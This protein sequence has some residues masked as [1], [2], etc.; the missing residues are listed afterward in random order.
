MGVGA[1]AGGLEAFEKLFTNIPLDSGMAFV[2]IQHLDPTHE[3]ILTALVQKY[4]RMPVIQ[5]EDGMLVEANHVY[6][7]P[8]NEDLTFSGGKLH[9]DSPAMPR[10]HRLPIDLFFRSLAASLNENAIGIILSGTGTDGTL[11][12]S[13]IKE[14]GGLTIVQSVEEAKY[15]GMPYSAVNTGLVDLELSAEVMGEHLLKYAKRV[16]LPA[17]DTPEA[18]PER[19]KY[20][21]GTISAILRSSIG[22]DFRNYKTNTMTRRIE[23]R[24]VVLQ[25][26]KLEEYIKYLQFHREEQEKL[27]QELLIGVTN[28]FRDP[29]AFVALYTKVISTQILCRVEDNDT[30][31]RIW[32][33]GC[34]TGEESYSIAIMMEEL[35]T[36][37]GRGVD[38]QIFATDIDGNAI[39]RA[40][41]GIYPASIAADV[42]ED[43]LRKYFISDKDNNRYQVKQSLRDKIVFAVQSVI[44]DPPFSKLDLICCRN[45][46]IYLDSKAQQKTLMLFHYALNSRGHL[47]LGSSE[48]LGASQRLYE[49]IDNHW[50]IYQRVE[51]A[52]DVRTVM[53]F[54]TGTGSNTRAFPGPETL[55]TIGRTTEKL[56]LKD[57]VEQ[58]LLSEHTPTALVINEKGEM[59]YVHGR[60]GRYMEQTTGDTTINVLKMARTGLR[61]PLAAAMTKAKTEQSEEVAEHIRVTYDDQVVHARL[62]IQPILAPKA[63]QGLMLVTL[64]ELSPPTPKDTPGTKTPKSAEAHQRI[65]EL[66]QELGS[67][68]EY[69]QTTVEELET[70][71]EE[72]KSTNEELQSSNEELQSTNEEL[73]TSK[74]EL[75]SIN[76]ELVTVNSDLNN[77][78]DDLTAAN[79]DIK[80]LL[81]NTQQGILFLDNGMRIRRYTEAITAI[82]KLLPTDI[83]RP[84]SN[85]QFELKNVSLAD[86][87][88]GVLLDGK[89]VEREV[90]SAD[91]ARWHLMRVLP[92]W[93]VDNKMDGAVV[94]FTDIQQLKEAQERLRMS[95]A[96]FRGYFDIG[97]VGMAVSNLQKVFV[98]VNDVFC[99]MLGYKHDVLIKKTWAEITHAEDLNKDIKLFDELLG[100]ERDHYQ[101]E[102]RFIR[103][104]GTPIETTIYV[105]AQ[106]ASNGK[107]KNFL[108][109]IVDV[110]QLKMSVHKL[111]QVVDE[112]QELYNAI[113]TSFTPYDVIDEN[114]LFV[115]VNDAYLKAWGYSNRDEVIGTSPMGHTLDPEVTGQIMNT[116]AD[117]GKTEFEFTAKRKDGSTFEAFMTVS[118]YERADGTRLF[119]GFTEDITERKAA[120]AAL[121]ESET[122]YRALISS[123]DQM[124]IEIDQNGILQFTNPNFCKTFCVTGASHLGS[125]FEV[126]LGEDVRD[127]FAERLAALSSDERLNLDTLCETPNGE[128]FLE[129][130]FRVLS[131]EGVE[132]P[133]I[134]GVG[135]D[136]TEQREATNQL[137]LAASVFKNTNEGILIADENSIIIDVNQSFVAITGYSREEC[138]GRTPRFLHSGRHGKAFYE[139]MWKSL[140]E[141]G[142][143]QG[144]IWN[145]RR[146]G[147][148]FAE[149]I[150]INRVADENGETCRFVAILSDV[151]EEKQHAAALEHLARHDSLTGLP[152]RVLLA[153]H[154]KVAI[155]NADRRGS[156]LALFY[157]D[158]DGFKAINDTYGH[159][160]GDLFLTSTSQY[161]SAAVRAGD[162]VSR[163]GGDEFII[164]L[165]D[166]KDESDWMDLVQR[167]LKTVTLDVQLDAVSHDVSA[168][169]GVTFYPQEE[170]IEADQLVRQADQAM[171]QAKLA[172]K[173]GYAVFDPQEYSHQRG[174][175]ETRHSI[176]RALENDEFVL[177]YQPK[178]NMRSGEIKGVEALIRWQNKDR[179]LL[180]P[181]NFLPAIAEHTLSIEV[182]EWVLHEAL[183]TL[184]RWAKQGLYLSMSVNVAAPQLQNP[185]FPAQVQRALE[186][187]P[188]VDPSSLELEILETSA[189]NQLGAV[190]KTIRAIKALGVSFALDD[191]GTGYSALSYLKNLPVRALKIDQSFV[192]DILDDPDDLSL[193]EA[194]IGLSQAFRLNVIA[195]GVETEKH[196]Q[197]LLYLGCDVAQ[198]FAIARPMA[199]D[200][201]P[202]W[203]TQW[204]APKFWSETLSISSAFRYVLFAAVEYQCIANRIVRSS[205]SG[206]GA[207]AASRLDCRFASWLAGDAIRE[208]PDN[209][210]LSEIKEEFEAIQSKLRSIAHHPEQFSDDLI[211]TRVF[212]KLDA[213]LNKLMGMLVG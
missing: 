5:V 167:L 188:R 210:Y 106:R 71:N 43:R 141:T 135:R 63:M 111:E 30:T 173:N 117:T 164:V 189:L 211:R 152:N 161:L 91:G 150:N 142:S 22:H 37:V 47:F 85:L 16:H 176:R 123:Q 74:E 78:V 129:W 154:L 196:G 55:A 86:D 15:D 140:N 27:F 25:L 54:P 95:E 127:G 44:K 185:D 204:K 121:I 29:E 125:A 102:K 84:L 163:I 1:S 96:A 62:K 41:H 3:S 48:T 175:N 79:N 81:D 122:R 166:I 200:R 174:V 186:A 181:A 65:L 87:L 197:A 73:Q 66:E 9:L 202:G 159:D 134:I 34:S 180:P 212:E 58:N 147:E 39:E 100:G 187:Y 120:R 77:K 110:S 82:I 10:G 206:D 126:F 67:T 24:M 53:E 11:G 50:K 88:R 38:Y 68:R 171:Y 40:R 169:I 207:A 105:R 103:K 42:S 198:G 148:V 118:V 128:R 203:C 92:Y 138:I 19:V 45:L 80:N 57:V 191:F 139:A 192:R 201:V 35:Q 168:S 183:A 23:R 131:K 177:H 194:I 98:E 60:T 115:Y 89:P 61:G 144:E 182:G 205:R 172:G 130:S 116:V 184:E 97:A 108:A 13:S 17:S 12:L 6:V 137:E 101:L 208:F 114:G 32:V 94:I 28:F 199:A 213:L 31:V 155:A 52:P 113:Q 26:S 20:S 190:S 76:E 4:T 21:V 179:G 136:I 132:R 7:I 83:G 59:L 112:Y 178:V 2:L 143:W 149:L 160:V 69:L 153:D 145:R 8:P 119:H 209:S 156:T 36:T 75:Q 64:H 93:T 193:L 72:L 162:T 14:T 170:P 90:Q 56:N 70:T 46:L 33:P 165:S 109:A 18:F 157:L 51:T 104:D 158:L 99:E 195:E 151:T 49:T 133:T 107:I 124:V 146:N